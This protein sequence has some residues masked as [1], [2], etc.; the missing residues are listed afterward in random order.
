M[1]KKIK[2]SAAERK[3]EYRSKLSEEA[4]EKIRLADRERRKQAR[5]RQSGENR[6]DK[7]WGKIQI[8]KGEHT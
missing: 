4:L 6:A 3:R 8:I 5:S 2:K 7:F 1:E